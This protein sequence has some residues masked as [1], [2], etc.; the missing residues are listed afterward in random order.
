MDTILI[1]D[2]GGQTAQLI[3]RRIRELGVY[4]EIIPGDTGYDRIP[5]VIHMDD[6]KGFIFSGSP[7]SVYDHNAPALDPRFLEDGRPILGICY[8]LQRFTHDLGGRVEQ[9]HTREFGRNRIKFRHQ[10]PLFKDIPEGFISWMS[11]GDSIDTP[12][13]GFRIIAESEHHHPAAVSHEELPVYGLQFHPEVSHCEY[14]SEILSNFACEICGAGKE[15]NMHMY[16]EEAAEDIRKQ[17]GSKPVLLL[18]SGGVDSTVVGGMLLKSLPHD[19]VHLMYIDTGLMRKNESV[20]VEKTLKALGA[21]HL[22]IIHAE[23]DFLDPLEGVS[24]PEKKREIIGDAFIRVQEREIA[25]LG[26]E[27]SILAQGTLYTDMIESGKGVG[28]KAKV[29]KSHHNVRSPLVERK[30][31]QGLIIEPLSKLYKDEVRA[32]GIELGIDPDVVN[33]H[34]FPGPGLAVRIIGE[35]TREKLQILREADHIFISELKARGLYHNIWQAFVVLLPVRSVGVTGD[36]REYGYVCSLRAIISRDGMTADVYPFEM[37]DLLEI[38]S[39]I[40]NQVR[41]IG[42]VAYDISSKP[43]ATIEWE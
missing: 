35:I 4:S 32:L 42:R 34:P 17:A 16:M 6:V 28:N 9:K 24:D 36:A 5:D 11:H 31:E 19:Q 23:K 15:W 14:G 30:R 18:I 13:P 7:E 12:A 25:R 21:T 37:N 41:H 27:N 8:G 1:L 33:R 2:F 26:V 39:R 22:H 38:S 3:A 20:K 10:S 43:P 29:I 40:T